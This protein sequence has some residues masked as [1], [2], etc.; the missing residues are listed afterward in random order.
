[1]LGSAPEPLA[2]LLEQL[3]EL[4]LQGR[5]VQPPFGPAAGIELTQQPEPILLQLGQQLCIAEA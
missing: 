4:T 1:M 3:T 2:G 5:Q